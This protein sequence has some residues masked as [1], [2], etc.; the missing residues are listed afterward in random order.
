MNLIEFQVQTSLPYILQTLVCVYT[1]MLW[2]PLVT[3]TKRDTSNKSQ[4]WI[5]LWESQ[6]NLTRGLC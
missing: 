6:E 1:T 3:K 5:L 2:Q 4:R